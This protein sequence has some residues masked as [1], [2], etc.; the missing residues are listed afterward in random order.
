MKRLLRDA[1]LRVGGLL[2][3]HRERTRWVCRDFQ[4]SVAVSGVR[5]AREPRSSVGISK[6]K[7]ADDLETALETAFEYDRKVVVERGIDARRSS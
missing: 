7:S 5:E 4:G 2:A 1:G 6:V 3:R